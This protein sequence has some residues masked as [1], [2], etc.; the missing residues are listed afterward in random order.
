MAL[1]PIILNSYLLGACATV[2]TMKKHKEET[3][4]WNNQPS[5]GKEK[6]I[7]IL[8]HGLNLKPQKMDDWAD[9]LAKNGALVIRFALFGHTG[10]LGHMQEVK[11]YV[12]REQ[13][14][15]AMDYALTLSSKHELP[16]YFVGFSLGALVS[17]EWL[18]SLVVPPENFK[19]MVLIAPA[20]SVPWYSRAAISMLSVFGDGFMLPSRS[21]ETY[22]AN[23]G[24]S[25]AAYQSLFALKKSLE[26][27]KYKNVNL[28]TLVLIDKND[29]LVDSRDIKKA[30][31]D[32][33]LGKWQLEFVDNR[34]AYD[35]FGFRHLMVDEASIGKD[36]WARL[37]AIVIKHLELK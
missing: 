25:I 6:A 31:K 33:S 37:T 7:V 5:N 2:S 22:R 8:L 36:L 34:F 24:T 17:L 14:R 12:W 10:D 28:P 13:F 20:L 18:A 35:N 32:F 26:E 27:K 16:L 23:K 3:L 30:M 11:P 29:E 21:P 1:I 9:V 15:E 19:K 4:I